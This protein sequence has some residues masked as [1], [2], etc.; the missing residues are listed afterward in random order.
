[1]LSTLAR[2]RG[3]K[4][5]FWWMFIRAPGRAVDRS[6][7]HGFT[8]L[9]RVN[10]LHGFDSR[11]P[12]QSTHVMGDL[13]ETKPFDPTE[14]IRSAGGQGELPGDEAG[15]GNAECRKSS[16]AQRG[17]QI[18]TAAQYL[19]AEARRLWGSQPGTLDGNRLDMSIAMVVAYERTHQTRSR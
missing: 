5:A 7:N 8:P 6:R 16:R 15:S 18:Y 1:V 13:D 14:H 12:L 2:P 3:A 4:R 11:G 10:N 17:G 19:A 9:P